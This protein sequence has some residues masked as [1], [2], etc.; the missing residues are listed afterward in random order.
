MAD[1]RESREEAALFGDVLIFEDAPDRDPAVS[2]D[3]TY[4]LDRPTSVAYRLAAGVEWAWKAFGTDLEFYMHLDD[5]SFVSIPRLDA[6][7][8]SEHQSDFYGH[9]FLG[10]LMSTPISMDAL[11]VDFCYTCSHDWSHL[12]E[13][14]GM[15]PLECYHTG[16]TCAIFGKGS[17][18]VDCFSLE[19]AKRFRQLN[20]FQN[21]WTPTWPL[22]MGFVFGRNIVEFI[23]INRDLLKMNASA[24]VQAGFWLAPLENVH[25]IDL[26]VL[27]ERR[28]HDYPRRHSLFSRGCSNNSVLVHRVRTENLRKE[29]DR[30]TCVLQCPQIATELELSCNYLCFNIYL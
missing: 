19:A 5:D 6:L 9:F 29:L 20:F 11:D 12:C 8:F 16:Q 1:G 14:F 10:F 21:T 27:P 2:R 7:I 24:D 26:G 23:A 28:F 15:S 3:E 25:W 18:I 30:D 17:S 4:V 22:G 13:P